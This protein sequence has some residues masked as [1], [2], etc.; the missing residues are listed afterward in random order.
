MLHPIKKPAQTLGTLALVAT[1]L[2][3]ALNCRPAPAAV[4]G[5]FRAVAKPISA[6]PA[7]ERA[8]RSEVKRDGKNL[9]CGVQWT[10]TMSPGQTL[11]FYTSNWPSSSFINW[12]VMT[13]SATGDIGA[14]VTDVHTQRTDSTHVT[15]W[16]TVSNESASS[17]AIEGRYCYL[18]S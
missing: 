3:L 16:I 14:G 6:G 15:Y 12:S 8:Q 1:T 18:H 2:A 11:E 13:D 10:Y 5:S 7:N 9:P 17:V 4:T